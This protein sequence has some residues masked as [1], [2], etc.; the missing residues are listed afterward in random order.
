MLNYVK[1]NA[2][3]IYL[4]KIKNDYYV[5]AIMRKKQDRVDIVLV[6]LESISEK[7]RFI[8]GETHLV[9]S[10]K[11]LTPDRI[12][13]I[14]RIIPEEIE[15]FCFSNKYQL[16][17]K[18]PSH[19]D[20]INISHMIQNRFIIGNQMGIYFSKKMEVIK[21]F[22]VKTRHSTTLEVKS[23]I[24][25]DVLDYLFF[26]KSKRIKRIKI[27]RAK[28]RVNDQERTSGIIQINNNYIISLVFRDTEFKTYPAHMIP[29]VLSMFNSKLLTADK[30]IIQLT[31]KLL[32]CTIENSTF[33][34]QISEFQDP[35][36]DDIK[37]GVVAFNF[38]D[39]S[40]TMRLF[41]SIGSSRLIYSNMNNFITDRLFMS[42]FNNRIKMKG[43]GVLEEAYSGHYRPFIN[44]STIDLILNVRGV[45]IVYIEETELTMIYN[46][47]TLFNKMKDGKI[48]GY[49][50]KILREAKN[51]M[52][53]KKV[54]FKHIK[55]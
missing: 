28:H 42:I 10:K 44:K 23:I 54:F 49:W 38:T 47:R 34:E 41:S 48:N 45:S 9:L 46:L 52:Q 53:S 7:Y 22:P 12:A 24:A 55:K 35:L 5:K 4:V 1:K 6:K 29:N 18:S 31:K 37:S 8:S 50:S 17:L 3:K 36:N 32:R 13:S 2:K 25:F 40:L 51:E 16:N 14:D 27:G 26:K 21:Y 19:K 30:K 20:V 11:D 43:R 39:K 33:K 15:D